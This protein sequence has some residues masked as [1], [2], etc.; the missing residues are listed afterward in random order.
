MI[1]KLE[2][3]MASREYLLLTDAKAVLIRTWDIPRRSFLEVAMCGR[4]IKHWVPE[5]G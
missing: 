1:V 3:K 5:Q 4:E 2:M